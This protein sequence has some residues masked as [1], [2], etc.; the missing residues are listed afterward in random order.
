MKMKTINIHGKNY[1]EVHER[2]KF[3][4]ENFKHHSLTTEVIEKTEN[5]IMMQAIVKNKDGLVI[6]TG[7]AEEIKDSSKVNKTSH[8]ENCETSA[9]GRALANLGIGLDTAIASADEVTSA[10]IKQDTKKWLTESQFYA[11]MK[12]KKNEAE[13]V[14]KAFRM[15]TE[16]KNQIKSKFKI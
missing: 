1:V 4:R 10:I 8:V 15:K 14:L 3:F 7:T 11:T 9:W 5:S 16:Y 2:V 6:A 12:G 13:N